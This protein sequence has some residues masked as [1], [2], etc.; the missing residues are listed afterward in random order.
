MKNSFAISRAREKAL[1]LIQPA[2]LMVI[3]LLSGFNI[4]NAQQY[5]NQYFERK[6]FFLGL[7]L[8]PGLISYKRGYENNNSSFDRQN[9]ITF[10]SDF[11]IG[12][13]PTDHLAIY[14]MSKVAWFNLDRNFE[15]KNLYINGLGG[16]GASYFVNKSAPSPYFNGG[17]GFSTFMPLIENDGVNF[18]GLGISAG[19]GYEFVSHWSAEINFTYGKPS[20]EGSYI[21]IAA[22]RLTVNYLLY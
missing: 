5:E 19:A 15:D 9:K 14:W 17:I 2:I 11:K 13:A 12:Y 20:Y 4:S 21:N 22:L 10:M 7:G 18:T 6:G 16:I 1:Q 3:I 8:G